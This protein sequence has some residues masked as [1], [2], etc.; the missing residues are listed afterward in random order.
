MKNILFVSGW[1]R[2]KGTGG[3]GIF[4]FDDKNAKDI[5][6]HRNDIVAM[7][8]ED[9]LEDAILMVEEKHY[10]RFPVYLGDLDNII[11]VV[12]MKDLFPFARRRGDYQKKI[13]EI[14]RA[15][16]RERV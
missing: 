10:S 14:G 15:S 16:C 6:V 7:N 5:M 3:V 1:L 11:G 8:G 4:E 12:H 13:R 9:T 2:K